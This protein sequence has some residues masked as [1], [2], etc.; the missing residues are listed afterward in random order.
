MPK[1]YPSL[2]SAQKQEIITRVKENGEKVSDLSREY[3]V[4][5]KTIYN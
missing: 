3:G 5:P 1:G 4:V 2:S